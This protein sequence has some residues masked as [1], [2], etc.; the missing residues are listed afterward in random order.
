M[1]VKDLSV[2]N[3]RVMRNLLMET[4][5]RK[6]CPVLV[7]HPW[8]QRSR[9]FTVKDNILL[10]ISWGFKFS[11]GEHLVYAGGVFVVVVRA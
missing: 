9:V 10:S 4:H 3:L 1:Y 8:D 6:C 11:L 5:R 2:H 7:I